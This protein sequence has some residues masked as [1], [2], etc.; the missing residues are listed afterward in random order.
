M[1]ILIDCDTKVR[2]LK[3][4][5]DGEEDVPFRLS[6]PF[7]SG[8]VFTSNLLDSLLCSVKKNF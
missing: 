4:N 8:N 1:L 2:L 6:D 3:L 5:G 7:V